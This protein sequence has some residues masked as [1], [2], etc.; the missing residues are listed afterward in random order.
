M[1]T[2]ERRKEKRVSLKCPIRIHRDG[3]VEY[4]QA[5]TQDIS[6]A[7]FYCL[8]TERLEVGEMLQCEIN[9]PAAGFVF[10]RDALWVRCTV[11]V[12]RVVDAGGGFGIGCCF[13][14]FAAATTT[15]DDLRDC[16]RLQQDG[17]R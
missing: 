11:M 8:V 12:V 3:S 5:M 17:N 2:L 16:G 10:S 13:K 1:T 4:R 7:G 14:D 15:V 6:S 9:L